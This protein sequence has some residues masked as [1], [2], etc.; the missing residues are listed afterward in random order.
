VRL[1]PDYWV[2]YNNI[3]STL[4]NLGD[5]EGSVRVGEQMMKA[6]GG[7]PGRAPEYM[8]TNYDGTVWDLPAERAEFIVEMESHG[9]IGVG[10][11]SGGAEN[12]GVAQIEVQMHDVEAAALRLK[13][14]PVDDKNVPDIAA[15]AM[16][17][18]LL[19]EEE[20]D[21]KAA[22]QEWDTFAVAYA[23]PTVSTA[24]PPYICFA[25]LTYEK[26][27]QPTK[28]DAALNAVGKLTFVDCNRF[29]GDLLEL[30]GDWAGAQAWYAKAVKLA[31]SIPSGYYSWGVAL[32]KHG[33][34]D[35]AA[36]KLKDANQKGPHWADPLKAWGDALVKQG[37]TKDALAK[38]DDALKYAPN[39]KELK[40]ARDALAKQ[41]T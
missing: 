1:K 30:R 38:Y 26:T 20:E 19:A 41:K 25:A 23:N 28:A 2:G 35:G 37:N 17:R 8:Y 18:A 12:L 27:G 29:R 15:A 4:G 39:W 36:A 6:A 16:A 33:D 7:R 3:M 13:T 5:E 10:A 24:N 40:E 34:L 14:T 31:P 11:V 21:L 9:G 32:A 22:A